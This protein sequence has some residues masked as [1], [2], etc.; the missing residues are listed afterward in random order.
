MK[1]KKR[2]I[3]DFES[4]FGKGRIG[5]VDIFRRNKIF[6]LLCIIGVVYFFLEYISPLVAPVLVA[7]L[8][9][10]MFGP[11]LQKM[12]RK[13]HAR[14]QVGAIILLV[15]SGTVIFVILWMLITW[16]VG[17]LP[18][19]LQGMQNTW[20]QLE[21]MVK[22]ICS[23]G[24]RV[25]NLDNAYLEEII[26]DY[27]QEGVLFLE[28]KVLPG[29]L[30][31]SV[32]YVKEIVAIGGFLLIFSVSCVFL[33]KDY[34]K[35]MNKLLERQ[36]CHIFLEIICGIIRYIA[37]FVKAQLTIMLTVG[38]LCA[39]VLG[40]A[41]ISGGVFWGIMAGALDALPFLGTGIVL[42][43]LAIAQL[44]AG[45]Y[46]RGIVCIFLYIG[47]ILLREFLEPKLIGKKMGIPP[48]L[49]LVAI[50]VGL[51]L[52]GVVGIIKGPLGFVLVYQTFVSLQKLGW[53][54]DVGGVMHGQ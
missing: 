20:G 33:A 23:F 29:F 41:G 34:D 19:W 22:G 10:T 42:V 35:I 3:L 36:E 28:Q 54:K 50:Y 48:L 18:G 26:L 40:V 13:L 16:M 53:W 38:G 45:S 52:F 14:R 49:V 51:K 15:F 9:V 37:T 27:M 39:L 25:L 12:Q 31:G 47:C 43:P 24:S 2:T 46:G 8:F 32:K 11:L 21:E 6:T 44:I 30:S 7:M 5:M 1:N 4:K 17:S